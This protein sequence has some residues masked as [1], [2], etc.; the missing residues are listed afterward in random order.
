MHSDGSSHDPI[1]V[2]STSLQQQN[3]DSGSFH[4]CF[5]ICAACCRQLLQ[6]FAGLQFLLT[7]CQGSRIS[8]GPMEDVYPLSLSGQGAAMLL[9]M[10]VPPLLLLGLLI[11]LLQILETVQPEIHPAIQVA[12][13]P[14]RG[15]RGHQPR[16][17]QNLNTGSF[18]GL[19]NSSSIQL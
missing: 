5:G 6:C 2:C 13:G 9:L 16:P 12:S 15:Q 19:S 8:Q 10:T 3:C 4:L 18:R 1:Y 7:R 17:G 11:G 14:L